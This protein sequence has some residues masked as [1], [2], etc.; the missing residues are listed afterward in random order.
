MKNKQVLDFKTFI[1]ESYDNETY[2]LN[3]KFADFDEYSR[4]V[5]FFNS[6]SAFHVKDENLE[7]KSLTFSCLDQ[8]DMDITENEI[9]NELIKNGFDNYFFESE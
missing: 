7:F 4:A 1:K 5:D 8:D 2:N 9:D 3:L 6:S